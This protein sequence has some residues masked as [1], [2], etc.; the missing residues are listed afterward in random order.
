MLKTLLE[1]LGGDPK[2][3]IFIFIKGVA[4]FAVGALLITLGYYHHHYWQMAGLVFIALGVV[5]AAYG[6]IG[7]FASRLLKVSRNTKSNVKF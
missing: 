7:L 1:K 3:S 4:I 2:K 5:I 6:Y